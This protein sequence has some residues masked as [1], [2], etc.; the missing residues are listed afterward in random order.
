MTAVQAF[1]E[2]LRTRLQALVPAN[3]ERA[4]RVIDWQALSPSVKLAVIRFDGRDLLLSV[5]KTGAAVIA[6]ETGNPPC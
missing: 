2:T 1:A 6:G 4:V 5:T 3:R